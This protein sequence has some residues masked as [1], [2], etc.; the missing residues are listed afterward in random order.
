[1]AGRVVF[2]TSGSGLFGNIAQANYVSAK[3]AIAILGRSAAAELKRYDVTVNVIGPVARTRMN[4]SLERELE[5]VDP[6]DGQPRPVR[7]AGGD[8]ASDR[9]ERPAPRQLE[10]YDRLV[11]ARASTAIRQAGHAGGVP[12]APA[13]ETPRASRWT[14]PCASTV[15]PSSLSSSRTTTA[16]RR[17]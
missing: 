8:Q 17:P 15:T 7:D 10:L 12:T 3:A 11:L 2:T 4:D 1:M 13:A 16:P 14:R 6:I 5:N 9:I